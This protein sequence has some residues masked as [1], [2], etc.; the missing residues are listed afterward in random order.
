MADYSHAPDQLANEQRLQNATGVGGSA[1]TT[2]VR[3]NWRT[4]SW[5]I[6]WSNSVDPAVERKT[7]NPMTS[8]TP[9]ASGCA[10]E[11]RRFG[12]HD[13]KSQPALV[14]T[15]VFGR[16]G[17]TSHS[18][19]PRLTGTARCARRRVRTHDAEQTII[20]KAVRSPRRWVHPNGH[21]TADWLP[22]V[23]WPRGGHSGISPVLSRH[24][25]ERATALQ[26]RLTPTAAL[27][28]AGA[29]GRGSRAGLRVIA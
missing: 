16:G 27:Y 21:A 3:T 7:G 4:A 29:S 19:G 26:W 9:R 28:C 12:A 2:K 8:K 23:T 17:F 22:R 11:F 10:R 6:S 13:R 25:G 1:M 18:S 20:A 14:G 24:A 15:A 5:H